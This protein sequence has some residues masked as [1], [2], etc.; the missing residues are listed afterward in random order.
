M[1]AT[2][3]AT[4]YRIHLYRPIPCA[5]S[6]HITPQPLNPNVTFPHTN[7][8]T[9]SHRT[10]AHLYLH[11]VITHHHTKHTLTSTPPPLYFHYTHV[12]SATH[13]PC[14]LPLYFYHHHHHC[15]TL[16]PTPPPTHTPA[17]QYHPT[18]PSNFNDHHHIPLHPPPHTSH[19]RPHFATPA[20]TLRQKIRYTISAF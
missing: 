17:P 1:S 15:Y 11:I 20:K 4:H 10:L 6:H 16:T 7:T 8:R 19:H 14:T 13:H 2:H 12:N 3:S 9:P 5:P 18:T